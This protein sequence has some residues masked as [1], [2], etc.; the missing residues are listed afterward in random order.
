MAKDR[1][2]TLYDLTLSGTE[3]SS[4]GACRNFTKAA[5]EGHFPARAED[6]V[7]GPA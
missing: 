1:T 3:L 6:P 5:G 2:R 7:S 4:P